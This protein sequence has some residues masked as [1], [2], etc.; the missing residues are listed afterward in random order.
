[1]QT[2]FVLPTT[3]GLNQLCQAPLLWRWAEVFI[4]APL[5]FTKGPAIP[6]LNGSHIVRDVRFLSRA[7]EVSYA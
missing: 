3:A 7:E 6:P 1:M 4:S 2:S 5:T